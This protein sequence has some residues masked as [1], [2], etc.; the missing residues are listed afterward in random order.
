[1]VEVL[2]PGGQIHAVGKGVG[3]A[4]EGVEAAAGGGEGVVLHRQEG[5][6]GLV[7]DQ[8]A[9]Q[10]GG[11]IDDGGAAHRV[12]DNRRGV[13]GPAGGLQ[14]VLHEPAVVLGE[15]EVV[16]EG[17]SEGVGGALGRV[18]HVGEAEGRGA[19]IDERGAHQAGVGAA[20]AAQPG[21]E[22]VEGEP[23][24]KGVGSGVG[25]V[26]DVVAHAAQVAEA[27]GIGDQ[28]GHVAGRRQ[29]ELGLEEDV[30]A[31]EELDTNGDGHGVLGY[32]ER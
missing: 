2:A 22:A 15:V 20:I 6:V 8:V 7:A 21:G 13:K 28:D 16:V 5:L 4:G 26:E 14:G 3:D 31:E 17:H 11:G 12:I 1:M 19:P 29:V 30:V 24:E 9:D 10:A 32:R 18:A 25:G 27:G 23:L